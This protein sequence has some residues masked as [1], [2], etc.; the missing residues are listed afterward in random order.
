MFHSS[1]TTLRALK[2]RYLN[3]LKKCLLANLMAFTISIPAMAETEIVERTVLNSSQSFEDK[4]IF[5]NIV[6]QDDDAVIQGAALYASAT[7]NFNGVSFINNLLSHET[8]SIRGAALYNDRNKLIN[9]NQK[10]LFDGNQLISSVSG[11]TGGSAIYNTGTINFETVK[12]QNNSSISLNNTTLQGG[13]IINTGSLNFKD[14]VFVSNKTYSDNK[15]SGGVVYNVGSYF[16][17]IGSVIF[18]NNET[19]SSNNSILGGVLYNPMRG[20]DM[21]FEGKTAFLENK[22]MGVGVTG[23]AIH[24]TYATITFNDFAVF[25]GNQIKGNSVDGAAIYNNGIL[26]FNAG[27]LF[28]DNEKI[29]IKTSVNGNNETIQTETSVKNDISNT[30]GVLN[31]SGTQNG[32]VGGGFSGKNSTINKSGSGQ[33]IF[34]DDVV[35]VCYTCIFNQTDGETIASSD[36]FLKGENYINGGVLKTHGSKLS[37]KAIIGKTDTSIGSLIH[38]SNSTESVEISNL[39]FEETNMKAQMLFSTYNESEFNKN[40]KI[41]GIEYQ[42]AD[43][44]TLVYDVSAKF[45]TNTHLKDNE[46][47]SYILNDALENE[48]GNIIAFENAKIQINPNIGKTG[49]IYL[50]NDAVLDVSQSGKI[51]NKIISKNMR[52]SENMKDLSLSDLEIA[53]GSI[54]DIRNIKI[55]ADLLTLKGENNL[56]INVNSL[57]DYGSILSKETILEGGGILTLRLTD[58]PEEGIYKIFSTDMNLKL[59]STNEF[60]GIQDLGDGSYK[61]ARKNADELSK[62]FGLSE[63]ETK[64]ASAVISGNVEHEVF[65]KVQTEIM[66]TLKSSNKEKAKKALKAV[67]TSEQSSAQSVSTDHVDSLA[68]IVQGEM[69]R[70][71]FGRSGGEEAPRAKVYIKGLYDKTKSTMGDGFKARST[72]AVLGIQSEVTES[73]TFGVGY[74]TSQTTAKEDLRRTE[75]DT[76]TGFIS[77]HYQPNSWW[78]SGLVT[79]SRGQYDEEK[80]VLSSVGKANYNVDSWGVQMTTGY[81]I[82][83]ADAVITP[84]VG[85]RYLSVKQEGYTDTLGTTVEGTSSDYLTAIAG[86]KGAWDLGVI[87]PTVGINVGYDVITDDI[88]TLNTLANGASYTVNG[89]ALDRLSVGVTTGVE[90]K[91]NDRTTLKLEYNGSFRKEY[92]DHSGM[93]KLELKF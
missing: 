24:L 50:L 51:E 15:I 89:E 32:Y 38:Y 33:L 59:I 87:R 45:F 75:V 3:I 47:A 85:L 36:T 40:Q 5:K 11:N 64:A 73:L 8:K 54:F 48:D 70:V 61:I 27:F 77:A 18:E 16:K 4:I 23:G 83:I 88:S 72:G 53:E 30:A 34:S 52:L 82:K 10:T 43:G 55:T 91:L 19:I 46:Q 78:M 22:S 66:E 44:D 81:D 2:K 35:N 90:A 68:N 25:V 62:K 20:A 56:K 60:F 71:G 57:K 86:V 13:T 12:F 7:L 41:S 29:T 79:F 92:T 6:I 49:V 93:L 17:T 39:S 31:I 21:L 76:N 80:Q 37:Y 42:N 74:A 26:N 63:E 14:A 9:F 65:K 58:I 67:G 69:Q 1:R 84:E 28:A